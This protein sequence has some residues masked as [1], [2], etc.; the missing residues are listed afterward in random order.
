MLS[1]LKQMEENQVSKPPETTRHHKSKKCW[2]FYPSEPFSFDQFTLIHP[3]LQIKMMMENIA[4]SS[5]LAINFY[6]CI[7]VRKLMSLNLSY[8]I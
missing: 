3:V 1:F 2:S 8:V 6:L 7:T 4:S 5:N